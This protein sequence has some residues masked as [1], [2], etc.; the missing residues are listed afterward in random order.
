MKKILLA[1]VM[2]LG[3]VQSSNAMLI[4]DRQYNQCRS[5]GN[6]MECWIM[7]A[8]S[9]P[10]LIIASQEEMSVEDKKEFM[11]AE[12]TN[13]LEGV[14]T[15]SVFLNAVAEKTNKDVYEVAREILNGN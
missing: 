5:G 11:R 4:G 9:L 2:V 3:L 15:E 13:L 14:T 6:A 7:I 10:T 8:F 1:L 12:A